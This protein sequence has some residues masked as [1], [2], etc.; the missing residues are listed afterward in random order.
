MSLWIEARVRE[1][2]LALARW[3]GTQ[4]T[5]VA[6]YQTESV[7]LPVAVTMLNGKTMIGATSS[8]CVWGGYC[9][10]GSNCSLG[11]NCS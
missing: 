3:H 5:A 11:L 1:M 7:P 8:L 10:I 9:L 2:S 4:T 6:S